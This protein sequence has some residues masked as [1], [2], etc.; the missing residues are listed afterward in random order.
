[1]QEIRRGRSQR[2]KRNMSLYYGTV[3]FIVL[4]IFAILSVTV[5]FKIETVIIKG[6]SIYSAEEIVSA[7]GI[8]GGENMIRK[9]MGKAEENITS[10]LIYIETAN[11]SRKLPSSVEIEVTPCTETACLQ[12]DEG[13]YIIS[14]MGKILRTTESP[15]EGM[16]IF[17]G[18]DPAEDTHIGGKFASAEENKTDVIYELLK[19]SLAGGFAGKMTSF[20]VT[21]RV[22]ISCMYE[23][24]IDIELGAISDIDYK[25]RFAEEIILAKLPDNAEGRLRMLDNGA[26]FLSNADIEQ[27]MEFR[28]ISEETAQDTPSEPFETDDEQSQETT[29]ATKLNFE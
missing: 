21:S 12:Y 3:A 27:I 22:N 24:R 14:E 29:A 10:E 18:T 1:M 11:I 5:F 7:S 6:S 17:Y 25:F 8:D 16:A 2:R 19:R 4:V 26:Q 28:R 13:W 20:D 23:D 15:P 9:N